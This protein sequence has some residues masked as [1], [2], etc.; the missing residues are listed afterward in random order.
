[1]KNP[2]ISQYLVGVPLVETELT[3]AR[4]VVRVILATLVL[5]ILHE[6][7]I[8]VEAVEGVF[9]EERHQT[10]GPGVRTEHIKHSQ[11]RTA[12][13]DTGQEFKLRRKVKEIENSVTLIQTHLEG[14]FAVKFTLNVVLESELGKL[15]KLSTL[16]IET[17]HGNPRH[18]IL[19]FG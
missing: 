9:K 7:E 2:D 16:Q 17:Y 6:V 12:V 14:C 5:L 1:M 13:T 18:D 11:L 3:V 19:T 15:G 10:V 8:P 4:G